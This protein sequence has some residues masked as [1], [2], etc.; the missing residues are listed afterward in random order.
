LHKKGTFVGGE[1][2]RIPKK[3][4]SRRREIVKRVWKVEDFSNKGKNGN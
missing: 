1:E 3:G 4:V 2:C